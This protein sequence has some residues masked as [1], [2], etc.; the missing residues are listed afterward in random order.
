MAAVAVVADDGEA[1]A[2]VVVAERADAAVELDA[3]TVR[4]LGQGCKSAVVKGDVGSQSIFSF[5][6]QSVASIIIVS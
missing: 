1:V 4:A 6:R 3:V 5:F 2:F